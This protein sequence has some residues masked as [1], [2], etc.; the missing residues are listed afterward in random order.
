[1]RKLFFTLPVALVVGLT[2]YSCADRVVEEP[3]SDRTNQFAYFP[4]EIGRKNTYII[5]SIIFLP[6]SGGIIRDSSRVWLLDAV[7]D[8]FRDQEGHLVFAVERWERR[9]PGAD[10]AW[11]YKNTWFAFRTDGQAVRT[12]DNFRFLPLIFPMD[13]RSAWNGNAWIDPFSTIEV[14]GQ[15]LAPFQGWTYQVDEI[16]IAGEIGGQNFD[17]L[18]VV[19]EADED[20][21]I[22]RRFSRSK[23]ARNIGLVE[24]EVWILDS[25]YCN[26]MPSP[27]DCA[28][29]PWLDKAEAG[30]VIKMTIVDHQ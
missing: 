7:A 9:G 12:E 27:P 22:E 2:C 28:T 25:Q 6:G 5:D 1:M 11:Q 26:Q 14:G 24:R 29:K 3:S 8:T 17:S 16:D 20:N 21:L 10:S 23:Y 18:L 19:T 13:S 4:L 30:F 15:T